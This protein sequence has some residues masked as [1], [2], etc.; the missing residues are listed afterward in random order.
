MPFHLPTALMSWYRAFSATSSQTRTPDVIWFTNLRAQCKYVGA[1]YGM[2]LLPVLLMRNL[3]TSKLTKDEKSLRI[4]FSLRFWSCVW[5][6][7]VRGTCPGR[8]RRWLVRYIQ[9]LW[10]VGKTCWGIVLCRCDHLYP[11][12]CEAPLLCGWNRLFLFQYVFN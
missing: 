11:Q 3:T 7:K 5:S 4:H 2:L 10:M 1:N 9:C 8:R 6:T 12:R